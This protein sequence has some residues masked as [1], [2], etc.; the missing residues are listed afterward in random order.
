MF[1]YSYSSPPPPPHSFLSPNVS[2]S[3]PRIS[4]PS[5]LSPKIFP[6]SSLYL[7][8]LP[9]LPHL[10]SSLNA[11]NLS[12][13]RP[14][15][16]ASFYPRLHGNPL[17]VLHPSLRPPVSVSSPCLEGCPTNAPSLSA[18]FSSSTPPCSS[19]HSSKACF[20]RLLWA[21]HRRSAEALIFA[22]TLSALCR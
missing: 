20:R 18:S 16:I 3:L 17:R 21:S 2:L 10:F 8:F 5:P 19:S 12:N 15:A 7:I 4:P 13:R 22:H 11:L 9:P 1:N 14:P 6:P